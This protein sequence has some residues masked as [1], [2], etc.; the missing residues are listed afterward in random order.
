MNR[1]PRIRFSA[2]RFKTCKQEVKV[3]QHNLGNKPKFIPQQPVFVR[4]FGK[5]AKWVPS[6][7]TETVSLRN[8]NVQVG[9][10]L[11]K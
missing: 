2:L 4:N 10:T 8:F 6:R 1:Q 5:G 9:D 7:I 3:F 11:W